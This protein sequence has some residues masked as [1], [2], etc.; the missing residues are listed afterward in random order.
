M[1]SLNQSVIFLKKYKKAIFS[2]ILLF[3]YVINSASFYVNSQPIENPFP[4][5]SLQSLTYF[6]PIHY[7]A[8][9]GRARG[10]IDYFNHSIYM[11]NGCNS[12]TNCTQYDIIKFGLS[13]NFQSVLNS[14][15]IPVKLNNFNNFDNTFQDFTTN[16]T[17]FFKVGF[18]KVYRIQPQFNNTS[19]I[20]SSWANFSCSFPSEIST[21]VRGCEIL[22]IKSI[23]NLLIILKTFF[24]KADI[25]TIYSSLETINTATN[26]SINEYLLPSNNTYEY[27]SKFDINH[28][29]LRYQGGYFLFNI[30]SHTLKPYKEPNIPEI[31]INNIQGLYGSNWPLIIGNMTI[32]F[33]ESR[34]NTGAYLI[35]YAIFKL[36]PS[37]TSGNVDLNIGIYIILALVVLVIY[38]IGFIK[39]A[40]SWIAYKLEI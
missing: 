32:E 17:V 10:S 18:E 16:G 5:N 3:I 6:H 33:Y 21:N 34:S 7:L 31:E 25:N 29:L 12:L 11:I 27:I 15:F 8:D 28:I 35:N 13:S 22:S 26:K 9:Y 19:Y 1:M 30:Y 38:K 20:V 40:S 14:Q 39:R 24:S 4:I 37:Y 2:F 36:I 23:G